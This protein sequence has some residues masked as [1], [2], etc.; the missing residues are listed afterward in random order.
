M[1]IYGAGT[2]GTQLASALRSHEGIDPVAF[3]DDNTALQGLLVAGLPVYTPA[4]I[5][6]IV[7]HKNIHR[8]LIAIPSL[9]QPK[10]AQI[11]RR[12]QKMGLEVQTLPSFAQLIGEEPLVEKL[13]PVQPRVPR[14]SPA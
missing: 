6:R 14:R 9:S 4:R 7:D 8:V 12:M 2:T 11:A 5:A 13:T 3:V 10:Q 1:L